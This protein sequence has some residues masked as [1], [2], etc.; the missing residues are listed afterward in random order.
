[1]KSI[2][3]MG[4]SNVSFIAVAKKKNYKIKIN[5]LKSLIYVK[6]S[7]LKWQQPHTDNM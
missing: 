6:L 1:M 4:T 7:Q 3:T 2:N 5:S